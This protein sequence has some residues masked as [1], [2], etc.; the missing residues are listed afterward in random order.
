M[1]DRSEQY[2]FYT[3]FNSCSLV[4][5]HSTIFVQG[6]HLSSVHFTDSVLFEAVVPQISNRIAELEWLNFS[7]ILTPVD[8]WNP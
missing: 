8:K 1:W 3:R 4:N 2:L 6:K 7:L 5:I